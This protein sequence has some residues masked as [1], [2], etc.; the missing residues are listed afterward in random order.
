[1]W[2]SEEELIELGLSHLG[3][4][5]KIDKNAIIFEPNLCQ[6]GDF[7]RIDALAILSPGGGSIKIGRNVHLSAG[8]HLFGTGGILV[9]D[10]ATISASTQIFS[11]SDDFTT[12]YLTNPTI[13]RDL[14]NVSFGEVVVGEFAVIGANSVILPGVNIGT[15]ASVGALTLVKN[16]IDKHQIW[17]GNPATLIGLRNPRLLNSLADEARRTTDSTFPE[18]E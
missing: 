15:G 10:F 14:R 12:G 11:V 18:M 13:S 1:M 6:V 4:N 9:K 5:V 8:C 17:S 7:S 2:L 16:D 3:R